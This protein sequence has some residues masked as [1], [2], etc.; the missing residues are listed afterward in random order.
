M[1]MPLKPHVVCGSAHLNGLKTDQ[2]SAF[3]HEA[4][5]EPSQVPLDVS[6]FFKLYFQVKFH[7]LSPK[8]SN[9]ISPEG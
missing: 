9:F 3:C 1:C 5:G 7:I 4:P 2:G 6:P 8:K